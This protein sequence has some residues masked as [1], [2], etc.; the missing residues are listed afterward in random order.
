MH[1]P[2]VEHSNLQTRAPPGRIRRACVPP[3]AQPQ[4]GFTSKAAHWAI[5][6]EDRRSYGRLTRKYCGVPLN[7]GTSTVVG[8]P[9]PVKFVWFTQTGEA[10]LVAH[11][12]V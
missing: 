12:T 4:R 1:P 11:C 10:R 9:L 7:K 6:I 5:R 3:A 8:L 2:F